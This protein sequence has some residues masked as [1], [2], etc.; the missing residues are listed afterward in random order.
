MSTLSEV[1]DLV[2]QDL[3]DA[4]NAIWS[5]S[6]IDRAIKK[7]LV[8]YSRICPQEAVATITLEA[9]GREIS[10]SALTGM[11]SIVRVWCPYTSADPEDPPQW[12]RWEL[13]GPTLMILDGA[14]P[15]SGEAVRIY[16]HQQHTI[17]GLDG[18][19]TTTVPTEDEE[20]IVLGA[21]AYAALQQ[22][23][24]AVGE[25][26]VSTETPEHWLIWGQRR[27]DDFCTALSGVRLR[28][29]RR[30]DKRVPLYIDGWRD[31]GKRGGI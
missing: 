3:D 31:E 11:T 7:A 6:D 20:V 27:W 16:Y 30:L 19:S 9:D 25:A 4:G 14:T 2:E 29:L 23:R 21:A 22:A 1:R 13:W 26:G 18:E 24:G 28:G 17:D 12:R 10:T 8:E 5:T 15:A